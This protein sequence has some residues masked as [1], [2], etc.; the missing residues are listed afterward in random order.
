MRTVAI[1]S[2][3][4]GVGKTTVTVHVGVAAHR[5]GL[6]VAIIDLDPQTSAAD[7]ADQRG[8]GSK[9]EA[10]AIPPAGSINY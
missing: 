10:V 5:A 4:G 1:L 9:P 6:D 2:E 3:K 7:W 8:E